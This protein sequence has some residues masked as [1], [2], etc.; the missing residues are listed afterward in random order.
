MTLNKR[1]GS[2]L[3]RES[4][5]YYLWLKSDRCTTIPSSIIQRIRELAIQS[6]SDVMNAEERSYLDAEVIQMMAELIV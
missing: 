3:L 2:N 6:A 5:D 4:W 1:L